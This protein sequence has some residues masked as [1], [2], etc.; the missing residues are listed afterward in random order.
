MPRILAACGLTLGLL[1]T[2]SAADKTDATKEALQE[3]GEFIGDWKGNGE[4][5]ASGKTGYWKE[6]LSWSWKFKGGE[7]WITL[8][9][10]D[11]KFEVIKGY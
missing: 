5:K 10:K 11:G 8:T 6:T 3:V 4:A 9:V 7:S 2:A 1:L